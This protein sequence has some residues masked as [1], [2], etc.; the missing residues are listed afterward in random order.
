MGLFSSKKPPPPRP[1]PRK[2]R[3]KMGLLLLAPFYATIAG[4]AALGASLIYCS[5]VYPD[6]L[7]LLE[8]ER[9]PLI[10]VLARDG[11]LIAERGGADGHVP[12]DLL[13]RHVTD[14]V[15]A[16]EDQRFYHHFGVDPFGLLRATI[17]NL[18]T[19]RFVQ[20][21]STLTQ[22]LAKNLYLTS[23][24]TFERKLEELALTFWL[25]T[26]L[27]KAD[28]LEL[29]LNRV[30]LGGGAY[31]I[32]AA[33]HRYFG[34]SARK[35]T[36]AEAAMIAGLLKAP[37]RY[38]PLTNPSMARARGRL[39]LRQMLGAGMITPEEKRAASI[40]MKGIV[41]AGR[42]AESAGAEY[43]VDYVLEQ[44]PTLGVGSGAEVIV[45]TT[46]DRALLKQTAE[47]V[48]RNLDER[49]AALEASQAA[50][51][52][53]GPRGGI[54]AL[55]GGHSYTESQFNRAVKAQRQPGSAFKPFV[56]LAALKAGYKPDSIVQDLPVSISGWAPRNFSG[57]YKGAMT[58]R[59]ALSRS[60]NSVAVRLALKVGPAR[61]AAE[62]RRLG[63]ASPLGRD[64]SLALGTSEVSL[65]EL[66]GAYN[67][68]AN[69]GYAFE[70]YVVS[71]VFTRSGKVIFARKVQRTSP[72][73]SRA[74]V[75][76]MNEMLNAAL[77]SGTGRRAA[78]PRHPAAGK[79]GTSQ[80]FR[81][82]WFVGYTAHLTAGV[83]VGNDDGQAM[84]RVTGGGL[85]A[86][87]WRQVMLA[88]HA[89]IV[90]E[91]LPGTA[92]SA[93]AAAA[94]APRRAGV[95]HPAGRIGDD[96]ISSM[97]EGTPEATETPHALRGTGMMSLGGAS[98]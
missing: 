81:D 2:R 89:H 62:A 55:V 15:I 45:E 38:S 60:V 40:A 49:G 13:P 23:A 86:D 30:Y 22:Q 3:S 12:I 10:R 8:K 61:V 50:V 37:S 87:I 52:V 53:L 98:R 25:E 17:T 73:V 91:A 14:A 76:A 18:R 19:G 79:T 96:F 66:A 34:K 57:D 92:T 94:P 51:V 26:R 56:Y 36:L 65:L 20:G 44:L 64:A 6:P 5:A 63:I 84:Q 54:R 83:W 35:L 43:A 69:G 32:D 1:A 59:T 48:G 28:I 41:E 95:T 7:S 27:S 58:M 42:P 11:S 9:P 75:G 82:A 90:P 88:A 33:A 46:L 29:Y 71:R 39:V 21:G 74:N 24:R 70:P 68:F 16:T 4:G 93:T 85:P 67:V 78:L 80:G 72:V 47:I 31:G 77:V 97:L